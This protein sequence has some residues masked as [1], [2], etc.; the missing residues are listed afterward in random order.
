[1][2]GQVS[3]YHLKHS[4]AREYKNVGAVQSNYDGYNLYLCSTSLTEFFFSKII[5]A[6]PC[7]Y[8]Q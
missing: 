3:M 7:I 6:S 2:N 5:V 8:R 1:M 4:C